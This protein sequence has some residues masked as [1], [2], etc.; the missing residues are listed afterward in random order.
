MR[1]FYAFKEFELGSLKS[2]LR[3]SAN[4]N[5]GLRA[6]LNESEKNF[7]FYSSHRQGFLRVESSV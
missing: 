2:C 5:P 1:K 3:Q 7:F 6:S 4:T